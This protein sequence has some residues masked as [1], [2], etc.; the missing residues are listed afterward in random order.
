MSGI[1]DKHEVYSMFKI[2][3]NERQTISNWGGGKVWTVSCFYFQSKVCC[4]IVQWLLMRRNEV[5]KL[6]NCV[7]PPPK[8]IHRSFWLV[9]SW[10]CLLTFQFDHAIQWVFIVHR[11]VF[12]CNHVPQPRQSETSATMLKMLTMP[13]MLK[14][15]MTICW[16]SVCGGQ[17]LSAMSDQRLP[18][19]H[20]FEAFN[21]KRRRWNVYRST[22]CFQNKCF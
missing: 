17:A 14:M 16:R 15:L 22:Y 6:L 4:T 1:C 11:V 12:W 10:W 13:A 18:C 20:N 7:R 8:I 19:E 3:L 5:S 2:V 21:N 9:F